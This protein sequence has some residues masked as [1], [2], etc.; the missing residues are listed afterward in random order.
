MHHYEFMLVN[1]LEKVFPMSTPQ[2]K[3][4]SVISGL[5]EET[6]S[7]QLAYKLESEV[8]ELKNHEIDLYLDTKLKDRFQIRSVELVP[9]ELPAFGL[10]DNNY[11]TTDPGLFPDLLLP[12]KDASL[13]LLPGQWRAIWFDITI[14]KDMGTEA[15]PIV[16]KI[17]KNKKIIWEDSFTLQT[18]NIE[19]PP[20]D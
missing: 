4:S 15:Y 13:K 20:Q 11:I 2:N 7:F 12:K 16:I 1:S 10:K 14:T 3:I 17:E 6:I 8:N 9:S 18:M 19:L 5:V